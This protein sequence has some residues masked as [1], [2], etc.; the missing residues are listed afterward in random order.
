MRT[1]QETVSRLSAT[2]RRARTAL[3]GGSALGIVAL[4]LVIA[5]VA[6]AM[7]PVTHQ[8]APYLTATP[9]ASANRVVQGPGASVNVLVPGTFSIYTGAA[10]ERVATVVVAAGG[11]TS[12]ALQTTTLGLGGL[13]FT[14][15]A[16]G[17]YRLTVGWTVSFHAEQVVRA[18]SLPHAMGLTSVIGITA[19]TSLVEPTTGLAV[20]GSVATVTVWAQMVTQGGIVHAQAPQL[21]SFGPA[22]LVL[23]GTH[24]YTVS[25]TIQ[26]VVGAYASPVAPPRSSV[27]TLFYLDP[28]TM[29]SF[30][31]LA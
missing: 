15:T 25:T 7:G 11:A 23:A 19:T 29:L 12:V 2:A 22:P 27:A 31:N 20:A 1:K 3:F 14:T 10:Q 18:G 26:I 9:I 24:A 28:A 6:A 13:A 16:A 30:V 5:P 17:T 8:Q 4:V 21:V